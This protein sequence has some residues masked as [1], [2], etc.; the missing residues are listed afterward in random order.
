MSKVD[1]EDP[2]KVAAL[3]GIAWA[4]A[5]EIEYENDEVIWGEESEEARFNRMRKWVVT[6]LR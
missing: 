5:A 4:L 1:P 2:E 3:F 6:N